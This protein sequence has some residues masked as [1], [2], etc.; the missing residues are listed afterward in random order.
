M[1]IITILGGIASVIDIIEGVVD[2]TRWVIKVVKWIIE[3]IHNEKSEPSAS[4]RFR[5][6]QV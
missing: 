4:N 1:L 2:F 5:L 6:T 3:K